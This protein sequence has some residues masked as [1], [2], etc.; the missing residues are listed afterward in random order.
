MIWV[1]LMAERFTIDRIVAVVRPPERD[2][3]RALLVGPAEHC[4]RAASTPVFS[5]GRTFRTLGF[6]DADWP[7][8]P[9]ALGRSSDLARHIHER[10]AETVVICGYFEDGEFRAVVDTALTSGCEL[11]S[12]PRTPEVAGVRPTFVYRNGEPLVTL[13]APVL[14]G[15]QLFVKRLADIVVSAVAL[16]LASPLML[17][18]AAAVRLDSRGPAL[19]SQERVGLGGRRFRIYKFRTMGVGAEERL[20]DVRSHSIYSDHRL[21]KVLSDPRVTRVGAWLRR[22]SLDELP[23]LWNVLKGDMALVGPRPPV[24]DEVALY[25]AHHYAR[26]DV[27]PGITGPWQVGGRN[28][29]TDFEEVVR[30]ETA[31]I[32]DWSIWTDISIF[33]RTIPVV[34]RMRGAH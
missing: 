16:S 29:I 24:P 14:K 5:S 15:Q 33:V 1:G 19:F 25:E 34:V 32:R 2:A 18:I 13:T 30:I 8:A 23:Q 26:F 31:Y 21:F 10:N 20:E 22:T 4:R 28:Q 6:L 7:A 17:L 11:V 27:K 12:V 9:D 3:P